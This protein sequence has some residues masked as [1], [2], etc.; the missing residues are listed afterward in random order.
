MVHKII[1]GP[2]ANKAKKI[3]KKTNC[4]YISS[5]VGLGVGW[6][7]LCVFKTEKGIAL[8]FDYIYIFFLLLPC[9]RAHPYIRQQQ[10]QQPKT[11]IHYS[12]R[13]AVTTEGGG[14]ARG[15]IAEKDYKIYN[16]F[17]FCL[18]HNKIYRGAQSLVLVS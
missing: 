9:H 6:V 17:S 1:H 8:F 14:R 12:Q 5:I 2:R 16:R 4:V 13:V 10:Q 18:C 3:R 11:N 7:Y 15:Y